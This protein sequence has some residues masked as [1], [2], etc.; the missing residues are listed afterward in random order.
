M[1]CMDKLTDNIL[2]GLI[3]LRDI[4]HEIAAAVYDTSTWIK[5]D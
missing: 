4:P 5:N 2:F 1:M 3:I